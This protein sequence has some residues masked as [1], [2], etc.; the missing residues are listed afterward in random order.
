MFLVIRADKASFEKG[1]QRMRSF[2]VKVSEDINWGEG[3]KLFAGKRKNFR[4]RLIVPLAGVKK[5]ILSRTITITLYSREN[6]E[7]WEF[8][9]SNSSFPFQ[10]FFTFL[11][12]SRNN[13]LYTLATSIF[14]FL[15]LPPIFPRSRIILERI[16][17]KLPLV[18]RLY[19][20]PFSFPFEKLREER[21]DARAVKLHRFL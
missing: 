2:V 7:T 8:I 3:R 4:F 12:L 16:S 13:N 5:Y 6:S 19:T 17:Q 10:I 14:L 18:S 9:S 11:V 20:H 1:I 15:L 21:R